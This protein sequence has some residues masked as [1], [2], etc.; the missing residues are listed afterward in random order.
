MS[1][2]RGGSFSRGGGGRIFKKISKILTTFFLGQ[3][4]WFFE[5]S[6]STVLPLFWQYFLRRRQIFEKTVKKQKKAVKKQF[7][8]SPSKLVYIGAE[9]PFRKILGSVGQKWISEKVSKGGPFGSAGG[10]I[11]ERERPPPSPRPP[12]LNPPLSKTIGLIKLRML[13]KLLGNLFELQSNHVQKYW[14]WRCGAL[15]LIVTSNRNHMIVGSNPT[16]AAF[17][18]VSSCKTDNHSSVILYWL[19]SWSGFWLVNYRKITLWEEQSNGYFCWRRPP[20]KSGSR[21]GG[22]QWPVDSKGASTGLPV[23]PRTPTQSR[24]EGRNGGYWI[25]LCFWERNFVWKDGGRRR[26]KK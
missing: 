6:Q 19:T 17:F 2:T 10:R 15:V 24:R 18:N 16:R 14:T 22:L 23:H 13:S 1:M 8:R 9:G 5:L 20:T 3:P 21:P 11:P 4:N 12:P 7:A 25:R 26:K